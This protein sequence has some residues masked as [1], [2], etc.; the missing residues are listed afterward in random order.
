[1]V[2]FSDLTA[3]LYR[4][5]FANLSGLS[6]WSLEETEIIESRALRRANH[7]AYPSQW[8]ARSAVRDYGVPAERVSVFPM[9]ANLDE[10]PTTDAIAAARNKPQERNCRILFIGVDWERKAATWHWKQCV[11][12][13]PAASMQL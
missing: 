3:R 1:V 7:V 10:V 9:G 11:G 12:C 13:A 2:Y 6:S 5:Y 8:V 4:N